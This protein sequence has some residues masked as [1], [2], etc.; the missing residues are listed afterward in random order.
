MNVTGRLPGVGVIYNPRSSYNRRHANAARRLER[1]LG[2]RGVVRKTDSI[3]ALHRTAEEFKKLDIDLLC[4]SGGDGTNGVT[5]TGFLAAYAGGRLPKIAILRGGTA[6]TLADSIGIPRAR[7]ET[8]LERVLK[9]YA[10]NGEQV[11]ETERHVL[12]VCGENSR[13]R[14]S[15]RDSIPPG[16]ASYGFLCGVGVVCGYLQELYAS[17]PPSARVAAKTLARAIGSTLVQGPMIRRMAAPFRGSAEFDD[18]ARWGERDYLSIAT[19]TIEQIGLGFKPF[20]RAQQHPG[21][22]HVLG[23]HTSPLGFVS[24]LPNIWRGK[25]MAARHSYESLARRVRIYGA[26]ARIDYMVD[27]DL[28]ACDGPLELSV[29]PLVRIVRL[30]AGATEHR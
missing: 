28:Y 5:L 1:T 26:A 16:T 19:G 4:I 20:F 23:I 27:G 13:R 21:T 30:S 9:A 18:G 2:D 25:P 8:L 24:Q 12:R 15:L 6:N 17:G 3:E 29:G 7:P 10:S 22:M 14:D 11:R